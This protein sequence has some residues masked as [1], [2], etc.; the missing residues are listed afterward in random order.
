[1]HRC[2][3]RRAVTK[4]VVNVTP[5]AVVTKSG[6]VT[7]KKIGRPVIGVVRMTVAERQRRHRERMRW[8]PWERMEGEG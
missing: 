7:K 5:A 1:M 4:A 3:P 2:V 8:W 6:D